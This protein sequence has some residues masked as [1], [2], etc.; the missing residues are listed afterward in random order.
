MLL[1]WS[2]GID[3]V[4]LMLWNDVMGWCNGIDVYIKCI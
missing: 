2:V 1:N 3:A 4:E